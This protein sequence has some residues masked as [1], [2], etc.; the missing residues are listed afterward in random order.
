M[1]LNESQ[2]LD[3]ILE[4]IP[5]EPEAPTAESSAPETASEQAQQQETETEVEQERVEP[6]TSPAIEPPLTWKAELKARWKDIPHDLQPQLAQWETE[7]NQGVNARLN[8]SAEAKKAAEAIKVQAEQERQ[9]YAQTLD[10]LIQQAIS[11]DPVLSYTAKL[12]QADWDKLY[13]DNPA[14]AVQLKHQHDSRL[15]TIQNWNAQRQQ[16]LAEQRN[17]VQVR[18]EAKLAEKIPEWR[19][20]AKRAELK[21]KLTRIAQER[22]GFKPEELSNVYDARYVEMLRDAAAYHDLLA[23]REAAQQKK[24][25]PAPAKVVKPGPAQGE[26]GESER[27]KALK[28]RALRS[29]KENDA[30]AAVLAAIGE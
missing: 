22:Y 11:I 9:R 23:A 5:D 28:Q 20:E 7:R 30:V 19:E 10:T 18:E 15:A 8:E 24:V 29:G 3:A 17:Q 25:A 1:D 27:V 6:E 14:Q 2:A 16:H 12:T 4:K 26:K 13:V 21:T